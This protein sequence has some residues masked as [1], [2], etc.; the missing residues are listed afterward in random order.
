[1]VNPVGYRLQVVVEGQIWHCAY[2][3][4]GIA[5]TLPIAL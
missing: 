2:Q 5:M 3:R 4:V 1:M